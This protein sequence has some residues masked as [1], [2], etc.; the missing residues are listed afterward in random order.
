MG[1]RGGVSVN[2]T[3]RFCFY[4]E[5]INVSRRRFKLTC[6]RIEANLSANFQQAAVEILAFAPNPDTLRREPF[7]KSSRGI[8]AGHSN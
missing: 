2:L 3:S 8:Y 7:T 4:F 6:Y 1:L 5:I